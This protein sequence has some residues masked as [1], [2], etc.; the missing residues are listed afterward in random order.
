MLIGLERRDNIAIVTIDRPERR[1]AFDEALWAE[2][3]DVGRKLADWLPRA[4]VLTG[5]GDAAFSAGQDVRPD[6]PQIERLTL[7]VQ[8]HE[9]EP[10]RAMLDFIHANLAALFD[11]PVPIIAAING[12]AF[13][14][15][16]EI[17]VRCDMRV[18]DLGASLCFSETRLGLM[19]DL[20]GG[21]ALTR[22]IG[23]GRGAELILTARRVDAN[24]ALSLGL[25][26]RVSEHGESVESAFE[27][28]E[29]IAANGPRAVRAA[30]G[31]IRGCAD[32]PWREAV[33][34]EVSAAAELIASAEC[35][36]GI[37]AFL[38]GTKA[39][40]PDPE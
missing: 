33:E 26:N 24:E 8:N 9:V 20:G 7:A 23:P 12:V 2:L 19:P 21:V 22:L 37:A 15:G 10:A 27:L 36:H 34:Q 14:G 28:A 3:G 13:G 35:T 6:N 29:E 1:N 31:V 5:A 40:F 4:V 38:S 32:L 17:A 25:V 11:V 16:A 39:E 30:L 18:M